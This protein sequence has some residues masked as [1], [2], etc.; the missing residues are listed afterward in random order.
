MNQSPISFKQT[1]RRNIALI[2]E[3]ALARIWL[4]IG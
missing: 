3:V 2:A 1:K 4:V